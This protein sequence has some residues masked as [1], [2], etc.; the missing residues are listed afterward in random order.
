MDCEIRANPRVYKVEWYHN[1]SYYSMKRN[2]FLQMG[3]TLFANTSVPH[4]SLKL[5]FPK[6]N[7]P[8]LKFGIRLL[9]IEKKSVNMNSDFFIPNDHFQNWIMNLVE[10][11]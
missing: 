4:C 3:S 1:V 10:F 6:K 7:W 9:K 2:Q 11:D 5:K 8:I